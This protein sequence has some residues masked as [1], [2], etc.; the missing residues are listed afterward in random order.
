MNV[1]SRKVAAD[2]L[3]KVVGRSP[4]VLIRFATPVRLSG[5]YQRTRYSQG[6]SLFLDEP[7]LLLSD[8]VVER[9]T[10]QEWAEN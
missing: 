5:L 9:R 6:I 7:Q 2:N 1:D 3:A 8:I 10:L 4:N